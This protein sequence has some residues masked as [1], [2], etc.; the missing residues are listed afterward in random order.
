MGWGPGQ[1]A[2]GVPREG[3]RFGGHAGATC[4]SQGLGEVY[5]HP[6]P[7]DGNSEPRTALCRENPGRGRERGDARVPEPPLRTGAPQKEPA[8]GKGTGWA[9]GRRARGRD[10]GLPGHGA[11]PDSGHRESFKL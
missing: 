11:E 9:A 8:R 5:G 4:R 3:G 2:Q 7:G 6:G 10:L 1:V